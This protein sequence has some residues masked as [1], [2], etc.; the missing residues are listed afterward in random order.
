MKKFYSLL[1]MAFVGML[2][3]AQSN[4]NRVLV[5]ETSG[6]VKGFLAERVDSISFAKVEGRVAAD[7][8]YNDFAAGTESDTLWISITRT[9]DCVAY[10]I[11][12]IPANVMAYLPTEAAL[13]DYVDQMGEN[14]YYD[15]FTNAQMTGID[16]ADDADYVFATVGYDRYAIPCATSKAEFHTPRPAVVGN[17]VVECTVAEVGTESITFNFKPNADVAGYAFC[18]YP[19]GEAENQLAQ[20]GAFFGFANI[21]EMVRGWGIQA[22]GDYVYTY[23]GQ[24]PGT[25]YELYIQ[26]WDVNGNNADVTV[27]PV[28]TEALGGEGV[29]EVAITVGDF[30]GD[31]LNGFYQIVTYTP[32]DQ[33]SF[34]RDMII[35]KEKYETAEWGEEGVKNYLM[36][37]NPYDP[38]WNQ[39][40]VDEAWWE[41]DPNTEYVACSIAQNI[42]GEWGP[43]ATVPFTTPAK[44]VVAPAQARVAKAPSALPTRIQHGSSAVQTVA[45]FLKAPKTVVPV[46]KQAK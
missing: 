12:C 13:A 32:N 37:D 18:I 35:T 29:A 28:K 36:Q 25:E 30:K 39:Y 21:G 15:D 27:V 31:I 11:A 9:A 38:Y 14:Y 20:W 1:I 41:A 16:L 44:A 22:S 23:T 33:A 2:A 7:V 45:P 34:H 40:G 46:L 5:H 42:N 10:K 8:T 17:P 26:P 19:A 43:L 4:P 3:W 6:N 24:T